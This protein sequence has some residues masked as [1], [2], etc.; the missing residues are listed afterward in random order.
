LPLLSKFALEYTII[1]PE[2]KPEGLELNGPHISAYIHADNVNLLDDRMNTENV[3][4]RKYIRHRSRNKRRMW[5]AIITQANVSQTF[6]SWTH[7][8]FQK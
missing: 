2:E 3:I 7:F 4:R 8:G 6:C 5:D 1:K